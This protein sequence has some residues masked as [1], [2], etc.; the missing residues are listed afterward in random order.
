METPELAEIFMIITLSISLISSS[1]SIIIIEQFP[2][3][4]AIIQIVIRR[5]FSYDILSSIIHLISIIVNLTIT[6][7]SNQEEI[8][9]IFSSLSQFSTNGLVINCYLQSFYSYQGLIKNSLQHDSKILIVSLIVQVGLCIYPLIQM[10]FKR[11][12]RLCLEP[13][14]VYNGDLISKAVVL[15]LFYLPVL[16]CFLLS[17]YYLRKSY[18]I[19]L[20]TKNVSV[21]S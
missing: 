14:Y 1:I 21:N 2:K 17:I 9:K 15:V 10:E 20:S 19:I 3:P 11:T 4:L 5:I 13:D 18:K 12:G 7:E 8:C 6:T 16:I